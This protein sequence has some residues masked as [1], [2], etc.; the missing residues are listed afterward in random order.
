MTDTLS[1]RALDI[2]AEYELIEK[3][4]TREN[5]THQ[6]RE[7]AKSEEFRVAS[8]RTRL[9]GLAGRPV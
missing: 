2:L 4:L 8:K 9:A 7:W 6:F 1:A 3:R 5:K